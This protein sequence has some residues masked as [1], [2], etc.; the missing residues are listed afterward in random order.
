[1]P[2]LGTT[3]LFNPDEISVPPDDF[4]AIAGLKRLDPFARVAGD[5][6]EG[7]DSM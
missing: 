7:V 6:T 5:L 4:G 3:Y 2:D 1:M